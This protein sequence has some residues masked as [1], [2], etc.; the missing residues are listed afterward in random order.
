MAN[1]VQ[2]TGPY[3]KEH[4]ENPVILQKKKGKG[5]RGHTI[6]VEKNGDDGV[7]RGQQLTY[8]ETE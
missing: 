4:R 3:S 5:R 8:P 7:P 1:I 2:D 6:L